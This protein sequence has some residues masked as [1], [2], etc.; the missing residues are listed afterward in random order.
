[1]QQLYKTENSIATVKTKFKEACPE[2]YELMER[3]ERE[4]KLNNYSNMRI[5]KYLTFIRSSHRLL[6]KCFQSAEKTD[7]E[8]F[9]IAVDSSGYS[10]W[11]KHDLKIMVKVFVRWLKNGILEGDYPDIVKWIKPKMK[12]SNAKVPEQILTRDEVEL[13]A[14][15]TRNPRD[16]ALVLILYESGCR[17]SEL[18]NMRIKDIAFDQFG[19]FVM[20]SGK[21]GWRRI[22]IIDYSKDLL[23]WLD[24]HQFKDNNESFVW[25]NMERP[26]HDDRILPF[27]VNKNI[28]ELAKKCNI[29]KPVNPHAFRHARA[30]HLAKH[31]PEA[32]MKQMFGWTNDS[33]MASVYFHLSGKDVDEALLKLHGLKVE[34]IPNS[35]VGIRICQNCGENNQILSHFC[36]KCNSPLDLKFMLEMDSKRREFDDFMKEFLQYYARFDKS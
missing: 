7:M 20:V 28:R 26:D 6:G 21:T 27:T 33:N 15:S 17:V 29:S 32:V 23:K 36:N 18:L 19:C 2:C 25:I 11:T 12:N 3:F 14:N 30:T 10:E 31:L 24:T 8:N 34:E 5:L 4:L 1:M 35:N 22:R 13:L 9:I 16:R